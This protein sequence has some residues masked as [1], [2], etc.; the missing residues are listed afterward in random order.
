MKFNKII[1]FVCLFA[2]INYS[3]ARKITKRL[4]FANPIE[5]ARNEILQIQGDYDLD[6]YRNDYYKICL[7]LTNDYHLLSSNND[8][9][10]SFMQTKII[11]NCSEKDFY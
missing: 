3:I 2:L 6:F 7:K 9:L 11:Y 8:C 4:P 5:A 1:L 10:Q